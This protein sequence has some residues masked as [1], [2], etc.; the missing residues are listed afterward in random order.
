MFF[1]KAGGIVAGQPLVQMIQRL[2]HMFQ[3]LVQR[4]PQGHVHFLNPPTNPQQRNPL[5]QGGC[6]QRKRGLIAAGI[7]AGLGQGDIL[8][9][10]GRIHHGQAA[11]H[12][13]SIQMGQ[14]LKRTGPDGG[15]Q[16][17]RGPQNIGNHTD[18]TLP[19]PM[20]M[21]FIHVFHTTRQANNRLHK[22]TIIHKVWENPSHNIIR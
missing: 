17:R 20:E 14:N 16:Q 4:A 10:M 5:T 3:I 1:G 2:G 19:H 12:N 18:K 6:D 8:P 22:P 21:E 11:R 9:I 15:N 7:I 13:Q